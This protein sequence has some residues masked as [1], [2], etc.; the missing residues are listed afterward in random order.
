MK[1][2]VYRRMILAAAVVA[3]WLGGTIPRA[4]AQ[5]ISGAIF[6]SLPDGTA[7]NH[8]LYD[9]KQDVYLNGGPQNENS[10]GLP[11]GTG[12]TDE[13]YYFQ[14]TNDT[15]QSIRAMAD[16]IVEELGPDVPLHFSAFHP[17]YKMRDVPPPPRDT[18]RRA[19]RLAKEAGIHHVYLGNV[20][21][22]EGDT[23]YCSS[24][25][26]ALIERN[27]Y[28]LVAW[29]LR[30]GACPRCGARCAGVFESEAGTWG[31]RRLA[32]KLGRDG[33]VLS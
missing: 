22:R 2:E 4:V 5:N 14:V 18:R 25:D 33:M 8:N 9:N 12:D 26:A 7:V 17:N 19:R 3:V 15:E 31:A 32:V 10:A 27:W 28:E 20:H 11:L 13:F 16:W 29:N 1:K 21:D 23:T 24:C 6:T 30:A